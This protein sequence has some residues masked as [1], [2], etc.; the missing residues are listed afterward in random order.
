MEKENSKP[1]FSFPR[2]ERIIFVLFVLITYYLY[3]SDPFSVKGLSSL[4][5]LFS[6]HCMFTLI[7]FLDRYWKNKGI[8]PVL[9][10]IIAFCPIYVYFMYA[11]CPHLMDVLFFW[12]LW[13]HIIF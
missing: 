4:R 12:F 13:A 7:L 1:A 5:S 10:T 3:L 6:I 9:Q 11:H 2:I 8:W